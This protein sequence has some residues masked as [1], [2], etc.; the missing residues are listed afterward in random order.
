MKIVLDTNVLVS[1]FLK[2]RS[3]PA[4]I[5]RLV[6]QGDLEIVVNESI[7]AEYQ[8]VLGRPK[9]DL[10]PDQV[11]TILHVIRSKGTNAPASAELFTLP[12]SSDEAFL[13]AALSVGADV[14]ITGNRRHFPQDACRGQRIVDPAE[15]IRLLG[16]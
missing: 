13:E 16:T 2:P 7:L 12:D 9:F 14:I 3:K 5:I 15:F 4:R 1:A 11:L 6:L 10:D 8:D